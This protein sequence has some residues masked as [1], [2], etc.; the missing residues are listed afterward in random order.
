M[1][2]GQ[3]PVARSVYN[4]I[5]IDGNA[6]TYTLISDDPQAAP[7]LTY[8]FDSDPKV[9]VGTY[10]YTV[11]PAVSGTYTLE[12][13]GFSSAPDLTYSFDSTPK[14]SVGTYAY[15]V[16]PAVGG[17]YTLLSNN[18]DKYDH[19]TYDFDDQPQILLATDIK[20]HITSVES[21]EAEG[22]GLMTYNSATQTLR[23]TWA[24]NK[25]VRISNLSGQTVLTARIGGAD[26]T[27]SV[28]HLPAGVYVVSTRGAHALKF[29][30]Q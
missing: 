16:T 30:K 10:A 23:T 12:S 13:D 17:S 29:I 22:Q 2:S 20:D 11:T 7:N 4:K 28:A 26:R 27:L 5:Q 9:S 8:S 25:E 19:L 14:V 6:E 3:T 1:V 18:P 15:T 21:I 24:D